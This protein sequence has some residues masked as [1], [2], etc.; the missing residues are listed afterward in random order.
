VL[1]AQPDAMDAIRRAGRARTVHRSV[2]LTDFGRDFC[3][4]CL[5]LGEEFPRT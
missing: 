4:V 1:E 3:E 5:P 2:R